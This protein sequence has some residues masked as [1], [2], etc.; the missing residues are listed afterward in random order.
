MFVAVTEPARR[1]HAVLAGIQPRDIGVLRTTTCLHLK[2]W[3]RGD[4][5]ELVVLGVSELLTNVLLHAATSNCELL[6]FETE[7]GVVVEVTDGCKA[8]PVIKEPSDGEAGGR[9]L[10]MLSVLA[11]NLEFCPL[12][13]GKC[14]RLTLDEAERQR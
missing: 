13:A 9:G 7:S 11:S 3:G 1:Y 6:M 14:V 4:L 10:Y 8:L 2:L 5:E 12:L